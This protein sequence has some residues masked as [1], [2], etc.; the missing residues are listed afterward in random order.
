[1]TTLREWLA[2]AP[3][4]LGMSSGFF[5]FFAH[6][7]VLG[8]LEEEGLLPRAAAG[9]SAGALVTGAWAAGV[10][11]AGIADA[12]LALE[13][14]HF[15]DPRPGFGLLRGQKFDRML[16]DLLPVHQFDAC[17]IPVMLSVHDILA[18]QT[19]VMTRGDLVTAI[20]ASCAVPG[21]FHPVWIG[22]RPYWD[23][24][25]SDR[26]GILGVPDGERLLFHHIESRSP[27][28]GVDSEAIR[29]PKRRG[30]VTLVVEGLPRSGPFKLHEGRRALGVARAA[31]QRALGS[32]IDGGCVRVRVTP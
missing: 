14:A 12:L 31:M 11:S 19:R 2:E 21:M 17:K 27:W 10:P 3:F 25:V 26:P 13:R 30:M 28:R 7:G 5:A 22:R 23:G 8:V 6:T 18:R 1:V 32:P 15:W 29:I 4:S 16:R 20:R 24:G 9:S